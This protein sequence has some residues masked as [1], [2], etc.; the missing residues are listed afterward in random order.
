MKIITPGHKYGLAYFEPQEGM[1]EI[2]F[3]EK[4][5][6]PEGV[7]ASG[8]TNPAQLVTVN[9]G[10]TNEE[11]LAMLIDRMKFLSVKL[12]SRETALAITKCEE[13][14]MWL[15]KRT[16]ERKARNVEGTHKA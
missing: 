2:Q 15:E 3:I 6:L 9:N 13:A 4:M 7:D 16:A 10:T 8:R 14:L 5:P 12:P 1:Q 11:V